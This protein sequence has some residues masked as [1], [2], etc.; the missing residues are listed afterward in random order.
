M[1]HVLHS[2]L[3]KL[4]PYRST[5][6]RYMVASEARTDPDMLDIVAA[7]ASKCRRRARVQN[8]LGAASD[9]PVRPGFP[10]G[11]YLKLLVVYVD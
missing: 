6:W 5:M 9:H 4:V 10:E 7:A 2:Q 3:R 8:M 1:A 11:R